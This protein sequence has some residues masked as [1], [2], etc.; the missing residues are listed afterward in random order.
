MKRTLIVLA[1][2]VIL[3]AGMGAAYLGYMGAFNALTI[4]EK[5]IGPYQ[6]VYENHVGNYKDTGKVHDKVYTSLKQD[7]IET[8]KGF[9][10]YFDDPNQVDPEKCRSRIG[11]ILEKK[12][13]NKLWK[14]RQK[15]KTT[16][17]AKKKCMVVEFPIKNSLSY[18]IGVMKAYP[19]LMKYAAD[20]KYKMNPPME[21]YDI[22]AK[23]TLYI[24]E[25]KR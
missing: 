25:I 5:M 20:K 23:K 4:E 22:P 21:I 15:F 14:A 12:D 1:A 16:W 13:Y 6:L 9:G 24:I 2:A 11:V 17:Y 3:L 10:I 19:V 8:Y 18:I 7:G